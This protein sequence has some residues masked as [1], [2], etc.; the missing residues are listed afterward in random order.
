MFSGIQ[1]FPLIL[2]LSAVSPHTHT[3]SS[4]SNSIAFP[5]SFV[6]PPSRHQ[7]SIPSPRAFI[8]S[9]QSSIFS[10]SLPLPRSLPPSFLPSSP[11]PALHSSLR[12]PPS[13]RHLYSHLT[14]ASCYLCAGKEMYFAALLFTG[15]S[16][17]PSSPCVFSS[18]FRR[19]RSPILYPGARHHH[20][21]H[22][23]RPVS[24]TK[25]DGW[26]DYRAT[27]CHPDLT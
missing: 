5:S 25:P 24:S 21:H 7:S 2:F 18:V 22:Q 1:I 15:F 11:S 12:L 17:P 20:Q 19:N 26:Q 23:Q 10:L 8:P 16:P 14:P 9:F 13:L 6:N 4:S 27:L 3:P